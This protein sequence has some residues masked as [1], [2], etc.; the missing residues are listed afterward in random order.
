MPATFYGQWSLEVVGNVDEFMQRVRIVGSIASDG[1]VAG[2]VGMQVAAID[3]D[4]WNVFLERSSDNGATWQT[5]LIQRVPSVTFPDGLIVTLFG[6]DD[7]V[8][9]QD[10]DVSVKFVYLN[11]QVNPPRPFQPPVPFTLP[12]SQFRPPLPP[13]VCPCCCQCPCGCHH[14]KKP[15]RRRCC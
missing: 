13:R 11:Q 9:P 6:D 2:A 4:G 15:K 8:L 10:S 14:P 3:G 1:I 7:I 5:N 12:P